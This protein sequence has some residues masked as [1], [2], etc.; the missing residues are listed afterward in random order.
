LP[1]CIILFGRFG[2]SGVTFVTHISLLSVDFVSFVS[3][4]IFGNEF[5]FYFRSCSNVRTSVKRRQTHI[6]KSFTVKP[7]ACSFGRMPEKAQQKTCIRRRGISLSQF[8]LPQILPFK[9][10]ITYADLLRIPPSSSVEQSD[11]AR[12]TTS[13]GNV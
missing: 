12:S 6:F 7:L 3:T 11:M 8:P 5:L 13:R 2:D 4:S 10:P 1:L 9:S